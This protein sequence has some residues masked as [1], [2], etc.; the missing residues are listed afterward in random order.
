MIFVGVVGAPLSGKEVL[1]QYLHEELGFNKIDFLEYNQEIHRD[2]DEDKTKEERDAML[3]QT[4]KKIYSECL[5]ND[6]KQ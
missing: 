6:W 5:K 2:E 4:M 3:V 1:S